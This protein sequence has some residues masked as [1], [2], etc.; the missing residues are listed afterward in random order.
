MPGYKGMRKL[1]EKS[2]GKLAKNIDKEDFLAQLK[3]AWR[4]HVKKHTPIE[5]ELAA[6]M[7]RIESSPF[8]GAFVTAGVTEGDIKTILEEIREEKVDPVRYEQKKVSRNELCPC[9]S[10]KKYKRCCGV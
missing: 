10:S 4:K 8:G 1:V 3:E 9:G 2:A 5:D 6:A 7:E